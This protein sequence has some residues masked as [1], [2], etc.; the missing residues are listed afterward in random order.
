MIQPPLYRKQTQEDPWSSLPRQPGQ[1]ERQI[2]AQ[3]LGWSVMRKTPDI[4]LP[5]ASQACTHVYSHASPHVKGTV[6]TELLER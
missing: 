3:N 5:L 1:A 6:S 2:M 4:Y